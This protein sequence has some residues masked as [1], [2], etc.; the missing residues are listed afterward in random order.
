M[1]EQQRLIASRRAHRAH[2]TKVLKKITELKEVEDD[3]NEQHAIVTLGSYLEQLQRK[4][5]V[6]SELDN[7]IFELFTKPEDLEADIIEAEDTQSFI[8]ETICT[9]KNF[10]ENKT[11]SMNISQRDQAAGASNNIQQTPESNQATSSESEPAGN[12]PS[13][14]EETQ[15]QS[16]TT[17]PEDINDLRK[18]IQLEADALHGNR[19]LIRRVAREMQRRSDLCVLRNGG[20]V[21]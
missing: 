14:P 9:T 17:P 11:K 15:P 13:T 2:L 12:Q 20:H 5:Q 19:E 6:L 7:K 8:A 3:Q 18:K 16:S 4:G 21:E 10:I 1:K